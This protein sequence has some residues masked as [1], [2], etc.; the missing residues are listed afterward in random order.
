[1]RA[2]AGSLKRSFEDESIDVE[3]EDEFGYTTRKY[4]S[5]LN[6]IQK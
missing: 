5:L 2:S 4:E 3:D 1:M 6:T